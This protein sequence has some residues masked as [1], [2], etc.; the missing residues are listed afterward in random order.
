MN[1][2]AK[3]PLPA[4]VLKDES[5]KAGLPAFQLLFSLPEKISVA[6]GE[7]KSCLVY[8][9]GSAPAFHGIPY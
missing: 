8:G 7:K 3:A 6:C 2:M 5:N 9:G 4:V 1:R